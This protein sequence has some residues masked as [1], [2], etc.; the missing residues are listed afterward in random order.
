MATNSSTVARNALAASSPAQTQA[1]D[2][3]DDRY[4]HQQNPPDHRECREAGA[5]KVVGDPVVGPELATTGGVSAGPEKSV[6]SSGH[7]HSD[8]AHAESVLKASECHTQ[9][10]GTGCDSVN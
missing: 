9:R 4:T 5:V 2:Q 1:I 8:E 3:Q 6:E 7:H 10:I